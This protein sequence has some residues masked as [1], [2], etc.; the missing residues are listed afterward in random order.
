VDAEDAEEDAEDAVVVSPWKSKYLCLYNPQAFICSFFPSIATAKEEPSTH[1]P[2]EI[3]R[4]PISKIEI[5]QSLKAVKGTT[6]LEEDGLPMLVWKRLWKY[7]GNINTGTFVSSIE[8]GY[9]PQRWRSARI[10]V[11]RYVFF[12]TRSYHSLC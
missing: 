5:H 7:L 9:H 8:L 2:A 4:H 6:A 10:A 12:E 3:R 11:L 1:T